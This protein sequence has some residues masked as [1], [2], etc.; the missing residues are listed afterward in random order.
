MY[1]RKRKRVE[2]VSI[3]P[4]NSKV[5]RK[6]YMIILVYSYGD[7]DMRCLHSVWEGPKIPRN[8]GND[9][10]KDKDATNVMKYLK[11][12]GFKDITKAARDL[13]YGGG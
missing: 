5:K 6:K 13:T 7:F 8:S 10:S 11:A 2:T 3:I 9:F 4:K 1:L 12:Q